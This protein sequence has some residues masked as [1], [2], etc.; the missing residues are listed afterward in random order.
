MSSAIDLFADSPHPDFQRRLELFRSY[1]VAGLLKVA[2]PAPKP[3]TVPTRGKA[4]PRPRHDRPAPAPSRQYAA[5]MATTAARDD[6]ITPNAKAFLQVLR[7]R[8][9]KGTSTSTC[10]TTLASIMS[11]SKRTIARYLRD[12]E[13]FGYIK[14]E[15]RENRRGL[16]T[17]LVIEITSRVLAFFAEGK[18]LAQ[19]LA[20]TPVLP[21]LSA[22]PGEGRVTNLS[23]KNQPSNLSLRSA[24]KM[25]WRVL[26]GRRAGPAIGSA[27][28][29]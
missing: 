4:P 24:Q 12:L 11:R 2:A 16:H 27:A 14:T 25:A 23:P 15:I 28:P 19:W 17:G 26:Q 20:E 3:V 22:K 9:G 5:P 29:S 6:R 21:D 7:A 13:A 1:G 10:K 8:C 18:G